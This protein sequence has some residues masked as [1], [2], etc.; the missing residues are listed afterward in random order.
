MAQSSLLRDIHKVG[1]LNILRRHG[2]TSRAHLAQRL[3]LTRSTLT[4]LVS[5][6]IQDGYVIESGARVVRRGLG[7]PGVGL[8]LNPSGAFFIGVNVGVG[9]LHSVLLD[10]AARTIDQED[11]VFELDDEPQQTLAKISDLVIKLWGRQGVPNDRLK[12]VGVTVPGTCEVGRVLLSPS[13]GWRDVDIGATVE[14]LT[15]HTVLVENDANAAALAEVYFSKEPGEANLVFLL[16]SEGVGGGIVIDGAIFRG[17]FGAAGEVGNMRLSRGGPTDTKGNAGTFEAYCGSRTLLGRYR[18]SNGRGRDLNALLA[19]LQDSNGAAMDLLR[20]WEYWLG[21]GI[22]T[23][24]NVL[25]PNRI[26][27]GGPLAVLVPYVQD[28]LIH[29]IRDERIPG[30]QEVEISRSALGD[31]S[32]ALGAAVLVYHSMFSLPALSS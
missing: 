11:E 24:V 32:S 26:V 31:E 14:S 4:H 8:E 22:L 21:A 19:D 12:G 18:E 5:D 3:G 28:R 9:K 16:L 10:L 27:V 25:N 20:D 29:R 2:V 23:L 15:H 13:L 17:G 6:L 30:G 7:R 1:A